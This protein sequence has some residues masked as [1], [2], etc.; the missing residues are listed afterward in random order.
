MKTFKLNMILLAV[1][2]FVFLASSQANAGKKVGDLTAAP[3]ASA[4]DILYVVSDTDGHSY[5][6]T[7]GDLIEAGLQ[8]GSFSDINWTDVKALPTA[9]INWAELTTVELQTAT[10]VNW[11]DVTGL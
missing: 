9:S 7:A 2:V 1:L 8:Q 10:G 11:T 4:E 6:I 5:Q 3:S